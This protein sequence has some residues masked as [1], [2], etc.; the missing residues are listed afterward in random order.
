[1]LARVMR[2]R[3]TLTL[4]AFGTTTL[5]EQASANALSPD[6]FLDRAVYYY[7]A[8]RST[9]RPAGKLPAFA[10]DIT[11]GRGIT[12]ELNIDKASWEELEGVAEQEDVSVERV[13]EHALLL[14]IA[15]IDSGRI[16]TRVVDRADQHPHGDG[17]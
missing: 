4:G 6:E 5:N 16:A 15:D 10:Q 17:P 3:L 11:D 8:E 2:R 9:R 7:L 12:L 14:L 1:M 13:L